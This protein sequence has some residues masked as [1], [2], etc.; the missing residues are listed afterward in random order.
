MLRRETVAD[1]SAEA[2]SDEQG[3]VFDV[4]QRNYFVVFAK[5]AR[6][7]DK[8]HVVFSYGV[9]FYSRQRPEVREHRKIK[10]EFFQP[11]R[12]KYTEP[13]NDPQRDQREPPSRFLDEIWHQ[14]ESKRWRKADHDISRRFA[15]KLRQRW[16]HFSDVVQYEF[17]HLLEP[18]SRFRCI[19]AFGGSLQK[20]DAE[21]FFKKLNL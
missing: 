15:R 17:R 14:H 12:K 18:A 9:T 16:L 1:Y 7:P 2:M 8:H 5:L 21:L 13:F 6:R 11:F 3:E 10:P 19:R 20:F 4:F